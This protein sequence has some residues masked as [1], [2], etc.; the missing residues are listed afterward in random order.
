MTQKI[1]NMVNTRLMRD[2]V[3][4]MMSKSNKKALLKS[5]EASL[6]NAKESILVHNCFATWFGRFNTLR[7]KERNVASVH[8]S[9]VKRQMM[10]RWKD[11]V[12][13]VSQE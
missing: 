10:S 1:T 8:N 2:I 9:R 12:Q 13:Q 11:Q 5:K 6:R 7:T 3:W 4:K